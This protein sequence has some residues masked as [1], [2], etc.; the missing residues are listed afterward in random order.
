LTQREA[1]QSQGISVKSVPLKIAGS[2]IRLEKGG[3]AKPLAPSGERLFLLF[4]LN[5]NTFRLR[6]NNDEI[7]KILAKLK[8]AVNTLNN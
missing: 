3:I 2:F 1:L 7:N 8:L 5:Q 4:D 6:W